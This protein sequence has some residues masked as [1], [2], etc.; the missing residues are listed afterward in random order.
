MVRA[1]FDTTTQEQVWVACNSTEGG[2]LRFSSV[3]ELKD[4]FVQAYPGNHVQW[5]EAAG[6]DVTG[7]EVNLDMPSMAAQASN[8]KGARFM[9]KLIRCDAATLSG[10]YHPRDWWYHTGWYAWRER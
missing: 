4:H 1:Q 2:E 3:S 9:S 5:E 8:L 7:K 6:S 10:Q